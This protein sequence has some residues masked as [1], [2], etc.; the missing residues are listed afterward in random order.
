MCLAEGIVVAL[1]DGRVLLV[2]SSGRS[3]LEGRRIHAR[4]MRLRLLRSVLYELHLLRGWWVLRV[5]RILRHLCVLRMRCISG[6]GGGARWILNGC[7][8]R[9]LSVLGG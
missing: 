6:I 3:L 9:R 2:V 1:G 7:V 4:C 5:L 8:I